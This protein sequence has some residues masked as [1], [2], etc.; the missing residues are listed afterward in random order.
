V[1]A[2]FGAFLAMMLAAGVPTTLAAL[3]LG[4]SSNLFGSLTHYASGPS[5]VFHA[6]GYTKLGEVMKGGLLMGLRSWL[7]WGGVGMAWW[8]VLGWW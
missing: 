4:Y 1:G 8:K 7:V 6:S 5:A 2:L 3:S